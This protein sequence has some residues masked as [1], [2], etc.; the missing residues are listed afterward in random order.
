MPNVNLWLCKPEWLNGDSHFVID[1]F[2]PWVPLGLLTMPYD[3]VV[4]ALFAIVIY[5]WS[6]RVNVKKG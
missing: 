2:T 1:N 3:L 6:Y 4:L 5:I